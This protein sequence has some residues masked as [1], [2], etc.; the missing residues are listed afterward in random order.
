MKNM[1]LWSSLFLL[2]PTLSCAGEEQQASY[3]AEKSTAA[4]NRG[5]QP[6]TEPDG[7]YLFAK[8]DTC[9]LFLDV[10]NPAPGSETRYGDREKP[11]I[12][13][14]FGGSF[15][16]GRRDAEHYLPWFRAMTEN[17]YR[18][19]SIDYRLGLK[20]YDKV[21][22]FQV[23]AL[24]HA[25]HIA[26]EDM[27]SATAYLV[28]NAETLGI[29]PD[30]I[31][32]SGSSAGAITALQTDYERCNRTSL[33]AGLPEGFRFA[34]VMAFAGAVFSREGKLRYAQEPAPT[35]MLHGTEDNVV[36]Y[37]QIKIF[38]LG[39]FGTS[40]ITERFRKFGY[41]Y[42]TCRYEGHN[43]EIATSMYE[44]I[45]EQILF[46]E[47]N[48]MKGSGCTVDSVVNNPAIPFPEE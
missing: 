17:G 29:D 14:A 44:T 23:K 28:E 45:P 4:D 21:G 38:R 13:F 5:E 31:V 15:A 11:T 26:V 42:N 2:L 24:E 30:N 7:T 43:H 39:F 22:V 6:V 48:V 8:R 19:V 40:K 27:V 10:Y 16:R 36:P 37:S 1:I 20:G 41:V 47:N 46:L 25:I 3:S 35:M 33:S 12:V 32:I 18:I 9:D 34:G